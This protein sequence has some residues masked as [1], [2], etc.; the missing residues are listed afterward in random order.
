MIPKL[1]IATFAL[2]AAI[3]TAL[4]EDAVSIGVIDFYGLRTITEEEVRAALPFSEG[5]A[6]SPDLALAEETMEADIAEALGVSRVRLTLVCCHE[7]NALV[8][9][10]GIEEQPG[11]QP[12]FR[13][14]PNGERRL[15]AEIVETARQVEIALQ[16]A[17]RAGDAGD[18]WTMG[19]SL[20]TNPGVRALQERYIGFADEYHELLVEILHGSAR[21]RAL[22]ATVLA[23]SA[24][25][26][27]VL[28][29]LEAAAL[30]PDPGVR[31]AALRALMV[32]AAYSNDCYGYL[33]TAKVL[34]EGGYETRC[35]YTEPGFFTPEVEEVVLDKFRQMAAKVGRPLP[36]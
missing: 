14:A 6:L 9:Y 3:S 21:G 30:D 28:P 33:P 27:A 10:V 11:L 36:E 5:F 23:Y 15:P 22:A 17:I 8:A 25:K 32:I 35:L 20:S 34:A 2:L 19:H 24:D 31:N 12:V 16:A 7:P 13:N 4:A 18:D 29:H 1:L 26:Q